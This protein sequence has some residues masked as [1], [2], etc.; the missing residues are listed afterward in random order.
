[1][2][3]Q[4]TLLL[5]SLGVDWVLYLLIIL[6]VL[7]VAVIIERAVFLW[8]NR[9]P[10][11]ALQPRLLAAL[12]QGTQAALAVL[13][14]H[15]GMAARVV[16]AGV[17][18][19]HRGPAAVGEIMAAVIATERKRYDRFLNFL[20]T[21]GANAPFIGLLGTVIGIMGAFADLKVQVDT[22]GSSRSA[23]IMGSISEAL[24]ATAV[25]L[26]VAIP[27]VVA[28]NQ[29]RT[30]VKRAESDTEALSSILLA[31]LKTVPA[32]AALAAKG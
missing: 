1:M 14:G 3:N 8:R 20:G 32:P 19:M 13:A 29:F 27:A 17:S 25:G 9:V 22:V 12:D 2:T 15:Q 11:A 31:H 24:V 5:D 4:L 10:V 6:S 18:E 23:M 16:H 21:L 28:Y 30:R 7:S 26:F